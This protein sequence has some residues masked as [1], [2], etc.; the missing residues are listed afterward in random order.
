MGIIIHIVAM[1]VMHIVCFVVAHIRQQQH[2]TVQ[3]NAGR[4]EENNDNGN[5]CTFASVIVPRAEK[6]RADVL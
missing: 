3:H 2:S 6:I 1:Q 4:N 5:A